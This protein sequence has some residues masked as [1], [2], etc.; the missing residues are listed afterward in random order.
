MVSATRA[1][2]F[3]RSDQRSCQEK[4]YPTPTAPANSIT[5]A[6]IIACFIVSDLDETDVAKE[7]ATSLAPGEGQMCSDTEVLGYIPIF[8]ASRNANIMPMAKM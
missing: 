7:L 5:V 3:V 1:L 2:S 4:I 8:Q 6:I